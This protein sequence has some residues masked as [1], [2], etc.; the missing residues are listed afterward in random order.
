MKIICKL[1]KEFGPCG[2]RLDVQIRF[3]ILDVKYFKQLIVKFAL[4]LWK[5][6]YSCS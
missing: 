2:V 4:A 1:N 3:E 6:E 5:W